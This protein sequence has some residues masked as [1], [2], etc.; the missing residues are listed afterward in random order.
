MVVRIAI[1][2]VMTT[3]AALAAPLPI[4]HA[5]ITGKTLESAERL[6][7]FL[8]LTDGALFDEA[9]PPRVRDQ[10]KQIG[11]LV[12]RSDFVE[13]PSG[14]AVQIEVE[15]LRLVRHVDVHGNWPLFEEEIRRRLTLRPG[16][17]L[18]PEAETLALLEAEAKRVREFLYREGRFWSDAE[19]KLKPAGRPEWVD[20]DVQV[21]LGRYV[22]LGKVDP[23]YVD[24]DLRIGHREPALS[25]ESLTSHFRPSWYRI[26]ALGRFSLDQM[27]EDARATEAHYRELGYPAAR[28]QPEFDLTEDLVGDRARVR[29]VITEKIK[30]T[31]RFIGNHSLT[32]KQLRDQVTIF[33]A[34]SYDEVELEESARE[35][36][37]LYQAHGFLEAQVACRRP[38]G[39]RQEGERPRELE[40]TCTVEEGPPLKVRSVDLLP[41]PGR[42][43]LTVSPSTLRDLLATK[44]FPP[45][46]SLGLGEG[47]YVTDLQLSQDIERIADYYR[48]HGYP[49]VRV[50]GELARSEAAFGNVGA[51]SAA[52]A[53]G[54]EGVRNLH[55]RFYI[56]EGRQER[57]EEPEF[58]FITVGHRHLRHAPEL[59]RQTEL[60]PGTPYT[61]EGIG[62][63][64]KRI[65]EYYGQRGHPYVEIG[66]QPEE[67]WNGEHTRVTVRFS[68]DQGPEV[69]FGEILIRGNFKTATSVI[70]SDLPFRRGDLFDREKLVRAEQLLQRHGIFNGVQVKPM[71][72]GAHLNPVP[73]FVEVQERYDDWGTPSASLGYTTDLG[74]AESVGYFWGNFFG[75]GSSFELRGDIAED[76]RQWNGFEALAQ[77]LDNPFYRLL[78]LTGRYLHPHL[79][80]PSLRLELQGNARKE[81]TVRLGQV[82]SW[83]L[84]SVLSWVQSPS[85]R[86]FLRYEVGSSTLQNVEFDRLPGR[87][88]AVSVVPDT[89]TDGKLTLGALLDDR[90]SFEGAKNPLMPLR[91]WLVAAT[92]TVAQHW[93]AFG[94]Q[95][96]HEFLVF[97]GQVQRYQP[98]GA[99]FTLVLNLRADWGFPIGEPALPAVERFFAGGDT[100]TRGFDTDKLKTEVIHGDVSPAS[101]GSGFRIIPQG[102]NIRLLGTIELQFPLATR[103]KFPLVGA[104]FLDAGSI[105]NQPQLFD[106]VRDVKV[107]IG[108]TLLRVLTPIGPIALEYAYPITQTV[109]EELWKKESWYSHWPGRIHFT[110]GI[111]ILR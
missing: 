96:S 43:D 27:R 78:S 31:L 76:L 45:F 32:D 86:L 2:L 52:V 51:L 16:S 24:E 6:L 100:S 5:V 14:V 40:I 73:I 80:V 21:K 28:V 7:R 84:S 50:R 39:P 23:I 35:L 9:M 17:S 30:V 64:A 12:R 59:T 72:L 56:D 69:R 82:N 47:G 105:F 92:A 20:L 4:R 61:K 85:F 89:T 68:I 77:P 75:G 58:E 109:A 97:S 90:V 54:W 95:H 91:G 101:S 15:P 36:H 88:D 18:P 66:S 81:N 94:A 63:A 57:I 111:P 53:T 103:G 93:L 33:Q 13:T 60:V 44:V 104:V 65:V 25:R 42:S 110:W 3:G 74:L 99:G 49:S 62:L 67:R 107:S 29:A 37:R 10:L 106:P 26:G 34:G 79:V 71:G 102:G 11:Y 87:S 83:A 46:G 22:R 108:A 70:L 48:S 1:L 55:V 38:R 98:L 19:V 8:G 41:E